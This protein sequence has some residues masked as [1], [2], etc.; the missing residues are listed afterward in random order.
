MAQCL[1]CWGRLFGGN[2]AMGT[3]RIVA[4][5]LRGQAVWRNASA[6]G[7]S[8]MAAMSLWELAVS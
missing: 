8:C 3:N 6:A 5:P 2:V 4:M 1:C 7:A